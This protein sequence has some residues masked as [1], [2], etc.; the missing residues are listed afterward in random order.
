MTY[1]R[2][3]LN[4]I[5][6]LKIRPQ[7]WCLNAHLCSVNRLVPGTQEAQEFMPFGDDKTSRAHLDYCKTVKDFQE[8][9]IQPLAGLSILESDKW[10]NQINIQIL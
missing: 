7:W 4:S 10:R 3:V 5:A 6:R 1:T 9:E 2:P 8:I